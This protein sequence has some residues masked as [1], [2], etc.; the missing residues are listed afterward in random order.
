M[1]PISDTGLGEFGT[2]TVSENLAYELVI[3]E[4]AQ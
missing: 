3:E 4:D 1:T 2:E